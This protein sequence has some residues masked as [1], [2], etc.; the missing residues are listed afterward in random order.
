M[1]RDRNAYFL[2]FKTLEEVK[3]GEESEEEENEFWGSYENTIKI[4]EK[5]KDLYFED[6]KIFVT[7]QGESQFHNYL[8]Y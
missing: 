4:N 8:L 5:F 1:E 3:R 7:E 6:S 2:D